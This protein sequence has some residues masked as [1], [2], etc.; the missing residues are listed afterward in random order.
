MRLDHLLSK[1]NCV[2]QTR[3]SAIGESTKI[4]V[5]FS[6]RDSSLKEKRDP[7]NQWGCSSGG[8]APALQAGGQEF[9]SLHLHQDERSSEKDGHKTKGKHTDTGS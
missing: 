9:E 1:E 2:G 3:G 7:I 4:V 6:V 5:Q 8:R